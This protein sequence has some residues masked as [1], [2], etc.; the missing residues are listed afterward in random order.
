[1][2]RS[3]Q[4]GRAAIHLY[5]PGYPTTRERVSFARQCAGSCRGPGGTPHSKYFLFDDVGRTHRRHVVVQTSMNLTSMAYTGQWNQAQVMRSAHVYAD[6]LGIFEQTRLGRPVSS[7][8]HT[9]KFGNVVDYFFPSFGATASTDPVMQ[10]LDHVDCRGATV[11]G[12][13]HGMT[14]IRIIQYAMYGDRGVWIAKKLR[15]LWSQG[16]DIGIIY[17]VSSRP[18][19]GILRNKSGRGAVP[20]KQSVV[21]DGW[22]NIVKYN[23]SKWMTITGH[24]GASTAA[25]I[26]FAGSANW[27]NLAFGDDEQMQRV[28]GAANA[29]R[30]VATYNKTW[31]QKSSTAPTPGTITTFGRTGEGARLDEP[32]E[33]PEFGTGVFRYMTED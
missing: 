30:Y 5:R 25:A 22:G 33:A 2:P 16:C 17:S 18:V 14:R 26:T 31:R 29:A 15:S 32:A 27:A 10:M 24:W 9:A 19:L 12:T 1:M 21:K 6:F 7:A 11:G 4:Q 23:H 28:S 3:A 20:M 13:A 8:Y